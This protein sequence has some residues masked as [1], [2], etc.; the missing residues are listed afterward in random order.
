MN[1]SIHDLIPHWIPALVLLEN[2]QGNWHSYID[3][4]YRYYCRDF[5]EHKPCFQKVPIFVRYEPSYQLKGAT[6][7]HLVSEGNEESERLPDIRR[8]ERICW[9]RAVIEHSFSD[10]R[11]WETTRPW[12]NQQQ[13]RINLALDDFSYL[14]VLG[15]RAQG[16]DLVTAYPI[17][18]THTREKKRKEYETF[19][20]QK[21]EGAAV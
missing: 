13:K 7:W 6:F 3:A 21:K 17:D 8:C 11:I 10:I 4:V 16:L 9:P 20:R 15:A 2:Y 19:S 1:P 14:V 12:K 18:R 5:V